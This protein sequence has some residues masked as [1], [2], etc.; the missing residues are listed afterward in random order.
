MGDSGGFSATCQP[1]PA[2]GLHFTTTRSNSS[3]SP[4]VTGF[5]NHDTECPA[6]QIHFTVR[7]LSHEAGAFV[8]GEVSRKLRRQH[9]LPASHDGGGSGDGGGGERRAAAAVPVGHK[10][11]G[12]RRRNGVL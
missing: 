8:I 9:R 12:V 10:L 1:Q 11:N 3:L 7:I 6:F 4:C 2:Q 5:T